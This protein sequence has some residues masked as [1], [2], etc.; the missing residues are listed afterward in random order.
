M[1]ILKCLVADD[2]PI[3]VRGTKRI[4]LNV[5][6][7][8]TEIF[9]A[10]NSKDVLDIVDKHDLDIIL[11]DVE[12]PTENGIETAK[13]ILSEKPDI[14]IIIMSGDSSYK[15]EALA[16]GAHGFILKPLFEED[17]EQCLKGE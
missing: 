4:A 16:A 14:K 8:E 13:K 7:E 9:E 12:M 11:L 6:G 15:S 1:I 17:L 3:L 5:L 10:Y 2:V